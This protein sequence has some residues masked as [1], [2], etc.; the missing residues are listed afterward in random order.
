M[1]AQPLTRSRI[2][3]PTVF[4]LAIATA[5][6]MLALSASAADEA[7]WTI[8]ITLDSPDLATPAVQW[9]IFNEDPVPEFKDRMRR[10]R[11][12]YEKQVKGSKEE[13]RMRERRSA[14]ITVE[15]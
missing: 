3:N 9:A 5:V 10:Y 2:S 7:F 6:M 4:I 13:R 11:G 14:R 8:G 12:A 15:W 1:D